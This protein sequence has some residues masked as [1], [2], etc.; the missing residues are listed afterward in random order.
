MRPGALHEG[1]LRS[2]I[3]QRRDALTGFAELHHFKNSP[4]QIVFAVEEDTAPPLRS[5]ALL[6]GAVPLLSAG[7]ASACTLT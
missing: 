5:R 7:Y 6:I 4:L 2:G 1:P 3:T